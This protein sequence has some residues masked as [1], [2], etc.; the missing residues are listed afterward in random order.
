MIEFSTFI[1]GSVIVGAVS[2]ITYA[3]KSLYEIKKKQKRMYNDMYGVER[4]D[5]RPGVIN[6]QHE[7]LKR[8]EDRF[9]TLDNRL[10]QLEDQMVHRHNEIT[11]ALRRITQEMEDPPDDI[12]QADNELGPDD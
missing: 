12:W 9:D 5:S 3:I 6:Q 7:E 4:D 11:Y 8:I 10:D 1:D 2:I